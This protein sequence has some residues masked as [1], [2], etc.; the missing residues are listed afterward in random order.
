MGCRK[1]AT[2]TA[3]FRVTCD[4][5]ENKF[6]MFKVMKKEHSERERRRRG[7]LTIY[8]AGLRSHASFKCDR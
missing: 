4:V 5:L 8:K 7:K 1:R 3:E 6:N 2:E